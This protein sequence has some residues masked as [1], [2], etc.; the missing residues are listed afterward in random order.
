MH[1][2]MLLATSTGAL[3]GI[4]C[5]IGVAYRFGYSG[6]EFFIFA[7]WFNRLLMGIVIGLAGSLTITKGKSNS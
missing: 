6:N 3:L 7:T 2:R 4:F 5:I 1:K